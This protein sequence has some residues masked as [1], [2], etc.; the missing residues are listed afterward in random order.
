MREP[1]DARAAAWCPDPPRT[2]RP[3]EV[4]AAGRTPRAARAAPTVAST[5]SQTGP[6][7]PR[8]RAPRA[9]S[10]GQAARHSRRP[11]PRRRRPRPRAPARPARLSVDAVGHSVNG[12]GGAPPPAAGRSPRRRCRRPPAS[13]CGAGA[14]TSTAR[15]QATRPGRLESST[16]RSPSRAASRTLWVTKRTVSR[17]SL[18]DPLELVVQHVAGHRVEGAERLVHEQHRRRPGRG[19]GPGRP[20]AA[21][22]RTAR[23]A[24]GCR[25]RPGAPGRAAP[26]PGPRR[27]ASDTP[28]SRSGRPTLPA[29]VS[30]G[31]SAGSWN[32]RAGV[33]PPATL[34]ACPPVGGRA[35]RRARAACS[36]R[37]RTRRR[38]R[39]TRPART[40]SETRSSACTASGAAPE[41]LADLG[42]RD[43]R[44]V[45]GPL[46]V[47]GPRPR[48]AVQLTS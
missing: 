45:R 36:C 30:H 22:R 2:A 17:R 20:A 37:S 32:I 48:R 4:A 40:S 6:A 14:G 13:R 24:A 21:C 34:D 28:R 42:Q 33:P 10:L 3:G 23:A 15:S 12:H 11:R 44:A 41:H 7:T 5:R 25:T 1:G 16:I 47:R 38:G 8:S 35:R 39:R 27:S 9:S 43:R 31:N 18:P 46:G 29:T 19:Y 26:G